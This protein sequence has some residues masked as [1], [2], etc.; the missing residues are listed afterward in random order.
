MLLSP[1]IIYKNLKVKIKLI[2][3]ISVILLQDNLKRRRR[4]TNRFVHQRSRFAEQDSRLYFQTAFFD[5][6][7]GLC[8][9]G[10]L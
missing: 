8:G 10:T 3:K 4:L 7:F 5:Q 2:I 6:H 1:F 9:V